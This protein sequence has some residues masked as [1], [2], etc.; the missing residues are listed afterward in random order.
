MPSRLALIALA[1][2]AG[3]C[4]PVAESAMYVVD[5]VRMEVT[6][7]RTIVDTSTMRTPATMTAAPAPVVLGPGPVS[8]GMFIRRADG[9]PINPGDRERAE[10]AFALYCAAR[11]A[12][13]PMGRLIL[14]RADRPTGFFGLCDRG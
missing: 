5:G 1:L 9:A 13:A 7:D 8:Q 2:L 14:D 3:A 11:G 12:G 4:A 6:R 10:A